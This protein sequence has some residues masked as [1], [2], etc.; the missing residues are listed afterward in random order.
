M[1][2]RSASGAAFSKVRFETADHLFSALVIMDSMV[3]MSKPEIVAYSFHLMGRSVNQV[4]IPSLR[5]SMGSSRLV[6][7]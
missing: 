1:S 7:R 5:S 2:S 4:F 3:D 6:R